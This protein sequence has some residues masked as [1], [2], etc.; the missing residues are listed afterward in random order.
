MLAKITVADYMTKRVVTLKDQA[1]VIESIQMMLNHKITCA[2]VVNDQ[3]RLV[4]MFSERDSM[5]VVLEN[6]YNQGGAGKV[7]EFMTREIKSV[8]VDASILDLA[9]R[10]ESSNIRSFPVFDDDARLVGIV[11]RTDVLK[12]L[13]AKKK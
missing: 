8:A 10:F 3:G 4:G 1:D 11:S 2:P 5:K 13:T 12:A 6:A 9:Q 7:E